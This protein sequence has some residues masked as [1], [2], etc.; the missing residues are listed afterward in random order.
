MR[1]EEI[2][3]NVALKD[4]LCVHFRE[5][6]FV[7][8]KH[9]GYSREE[10]RR[11]LF[12][13]FKSLVAMRGGDNALV[14][15]LW[16]EKAPL[17]PPTL[18]SALEEDSFVRMYAE[19][20]ALTLGLVR[21]VATLVPTKPLPPPLFLEER[22]DAHAYHD[23]S[24]LP[25]G[26]R[27]KISRTLRRKSEP[28]LLKWVQEDLLRACTIADL[29][30]R[31]WVTLSILCHGASYRDLEG[32]VLFIPS[33][34]K[35]GHT[36][37]LPF[38]CREHLLW[39]GIKTVSVFPLERENEERGFY[40]CQGTQVWPS[41][42]LMLETISASL[43]EKGV[44]AEPYAHAWKQ[45]H[46]HLLELKKRGGLLPYVGGHSMGGALA[47][48]I[49]L[50]SHPYL[51]SAFAFNPPV[52]E[53]LDAAIYERLSFRSQ[54]KLQVFA[55]IDD[56]PFWRIGS[57]VIGKVRILAGEKRWKY[58]PVTRRDMLFF[59]PALIKS[60]GNI[61]PIIL[62]HRRVI[63]LMRTFLVL[64]L[65]TTQINRENRERPHR[66][67]NI[68]FIPKFYRLVRFLVTLR[69]KYFKWEKRED[70]LKSRLEIVQLHIQDLEATHA[71]L[72]DADILHELDTLYEERTSIQKALS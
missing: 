47:S 69:R 51:E 44:A 20:E 8:S 13:A 5:G 12:E 23:V 16:D 6:G 11:T 46:Q 40:L 17:I 41:Q 14:R 43:S 9:K 58:H 29:E 24:S 22:Q 19:G 72:H 39:E 28:Q 56:F 52:V 63:F 48:Q 30:M 32:R 21:A 67:D 7:C 35:E 61:A 15:G 31:R 27:S 18:P 60:L 68:R 49:A 37:T 10:R 54:V 71:L 25:E 34:V 4:T 26:M 42:P 36:E 33:L 3:Q 70:Y 55:G 62:S 59:L 2:I 57:H 45:V 38:A 50:Y 64:P 53:S 66:F 65:T 1:L